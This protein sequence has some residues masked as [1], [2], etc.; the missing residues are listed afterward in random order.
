[1]VAYPV[2]TEL[3]VH[4]Q[5]LARRHR[6]L[7]FVSSMTTNGYLLTPPRFRR[8]VDLGV[9]GYQISFDGF[10]DSHDRTRRRRDGA[11]TFSTIWSNLLATRDIDER[12]N[13]MIRCHITPSTLDETEQLIDAVNEAFG[14]DERYRLFFKAIT[15]LGGPNDA[16][17]ETG[18]P[19]WED[20][21]KRRLT[22]RLARRDEA[23]ADPIIGGTYVCYAAEP[24]SL[25][26]RSNGQVAKCTVAFADPRYQVGRLHDTGTLDLDDERMRLWFAGL[27]SLDPATLKCPLPRLGA[28]P[29][30]AQPVSLSRK[31]TALVS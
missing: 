11:G 7:S 2:I 18:T 10:E 25:V 27:E 15:R 21:A 13:V 22:A 19:G 29:V 16:D 4:G 28:L 17:I 26:I 3:C 9:R 24:N 30:T 6:R 20:A 23:I 8:L 12:F 31:P 1:M 5:D 14:D